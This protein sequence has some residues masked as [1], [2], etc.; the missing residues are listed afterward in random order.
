MGKA[1]DVLHVR[2][3]SLWVHNGVVVGNGTGQ[4]RAGK[5]GEKK[6][7]IM[8]LLKQCTYT[9]VGPVDEVRV[10]LE[11][12]PV[13]RACWLCPSPCDWSSG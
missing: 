1:L 7:D 12:V 6:D 3:G 2:K 5:C 13:G 11:G 10:E 4:Q 9:K 8:E